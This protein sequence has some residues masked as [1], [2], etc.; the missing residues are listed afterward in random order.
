LKKRTALARFVFIFFLLLLSGKVFTQ[1]L[2]GDNTI[3]I[4]E[5]TASQMIAGKCQIFIDSIGTATPSAILN[6][7][8]KNLGDYKTNQ[9]VP[10]YWITR[11]IFLKFTLENSNNK[12]EKVHF[13]ASAYVRSMSVFK[14]F[15]NQ[16]IVQLKNESRSDGFQPIELNAKEK[17]VFIIKFNLT[18]KENNLCRP[19]LVNDAYLKT[20]QHLKYFT[21]NAEPAVGYLLSGIMLMMVLFTGANYLLGKKKEFLYNCIYSACMFG[22]IFLNTYLERKSGIL[23]SLFF[24]YFAFLL[25][26]TGTVFYIAF[27]R[28]FLETREHY[29]L[30]NKI[31]LIEEKFVLVIIVCFTVIVFFTNYFQ[32]QKNVENGMKLI[33][34]AIGIFFIV[35][36]LTKK[37]KLLNYL[38]IGNGI[39][40]FFSI[41]SFLLLLTPIRNSSIFT[42]SMLYYEMGIVGELIFFL[43]GLTYKNRVELIGKIKEQEALKLEAEKQSY[44]SRLAV[45]NAQQKERNRISA[46]MHDD[47]GAGVTAIRLYSE[48]AKKRIGKDIIP[49][50]EKISSSANELLNN[51]NAIIWTMSSSN[52]SLDNMVAY[53][54]SYSQ[55][56]FENTGINCQIQIEEGI[57]YI[58][59][60]GEIRRNVFLVVKEA[61]NNILKHSN[62]TEVNITLKREKNGLSLYIHDNGNGIDF[63]N[64]RK[65]GNGL[66][67]MKKR[68]E[69]SQILFKIENIDGTLITLHTKVDF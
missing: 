23:S 45:L 60:N 63:D 26:A 56:Y 22:L 38:A 68:M 32:L 52:D 46:D 18:K 31:F 65:F 59:V 42:S 69:E 8:W 28:K 3:D 10:K 50:I 25:L 47:L 35:F 55:E 7:S 67:N 54:R 44:E 6:E 1:P 4:S 24:E 27:A 41:I 39:L 17:S 58:A 51:M 21:N 29:P 11:P 61:L 2:P 12:A 19:Q 43:L 30:L 64:L 66:I 33:L 62:A 20:Y 16:Q 36:A 13:I 57:P 48:L 37:N 53:I 5:I 9:F 40:L 34:I 14:L 49:E 15:P